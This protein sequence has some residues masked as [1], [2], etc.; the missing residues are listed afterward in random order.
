MTWGNDPES[1]A[2]VNE[3]TTV[4]REAGPGWILDRTDCL[5]AMSGITEIYICKDGQN[6]NEGKLEIS[7]LVETKDEAE[8]DA[9]RRSKFDPAI[10]KIA[11]YAVADDGA[12]RNF[13]TYRNPNPVAKRSR[14]LPGGALPRDRAR[15]RTVE[16]QAKQSVWNRVVGFFQEG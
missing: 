12:Y 10:A 14:P 2:P 15:R 4:A 7:S 1:P 8:A 13:F 9:R 5:P 11:Y 3:I 6:L 16:I